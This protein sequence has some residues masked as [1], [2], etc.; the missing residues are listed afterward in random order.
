MRIKKTTRAM[1]KA[2]LRKLWLRSPERAAVLKRDRYTCQ[3][4]GIKQTKAGPPE[5][6]VKV[7]VHHAVEIE[8]D[9]FVDKVLEE[10]FL[11]EQH[12]LCTECHL[13]E[14]KGVNHK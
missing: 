1:V 12:V 13:K 14:H 5:N 11:S 8:W 2:A 3:Q 4:C 6:H 10:L 7:N 9:A